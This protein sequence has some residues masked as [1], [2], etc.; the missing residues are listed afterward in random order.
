MKYELENYIGSASDKARLYHD[1]IIL[2]MFSTVNPSRNIDVINLKVI[3]EEE[4]EPQNKGNYVVFKK[5]GTVEMVIYNFKTEKTYGCNRVIIS[6]I[7]YL[8]EYFRTYVTIHR[9][10]LTT[11]KDHKYLFVRHSGDPFASSEAFSIYMGRSFQKYSDE[12]LHMT[13][14]TLRKSLVNWVLSQEKDDRALQAGIAR[15]MSHTVKTQ[16]LRYYTEENEQLVERGVNFMSQTTAAA[17]D[18]QVGELVNVDL[19]LKG[20]IVALLTEESTF[21]LGK[22]LGFDKETVLMAELRETGEESTY[23]MIIGNTLRKRATSIFHP[24]DVA[25]NAVENVYRLQTQ[26]NAIQEELEKRLQQA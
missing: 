24:I 10:I 21:T 1:F 3:Y 26:K 25:Y 14:D 7:N 19:P 23:K 16:R 12:K 15:L 9:K 6:K 4:E 17:L 22:V 13:T 18:I 5:D 8:E 11:G 20:Q 2:L